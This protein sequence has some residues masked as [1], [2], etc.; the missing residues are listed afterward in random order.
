MPTQRTSGMTAI[1]I[2]NIIFGSLWCIG[3]LLTVLGGGVLAIIGSAAEA[4]TAGQAAAVGGAHA[5]LGL[6]SLTIAALLFISGIG[7]LKVAPWGRNFSL[8]AATLA[9]VN[10]VGKAV[11]LSAFG[12][13]TIIALVYPVILIALFVNPAWKAV[14]TGQLI[15]GEFDGTQ[16]APSNND[17][18]QFRSAA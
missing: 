10:S 5:L 7:V 6:F 12:V 16:T 18:D 2:L 13:G 1:G 17:Q 14:F 15:D 9:I 8:A 3:S 4:E 11:L